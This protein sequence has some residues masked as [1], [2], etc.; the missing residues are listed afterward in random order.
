MLF[1]TAALE[2]LVM[3]QLAAAAL[4]RHHL[5][6]PAGTLEEALLGL[7]RQTGI[8]LGLPN[9]MPLRR[10]AALQG[11]LP[12][13]EA[14]DRLLAGSGLVAVPVEASAWRIERPSTGAP[15]PSP[16]SPASRLVTIEPLPGPLPEIV[17]TAAK[18]SEPLASTP[19]DHA[20]ISADMLERQTGLAGSAMVTDYDNSLAFSNIGPGRN[21]PFLR[22]VGD[23]PFNGQT[24]STVAVMLDDA[25]ITF[26]APDPD[27]RLVD[28]ERVELLKGPQGPLMAPAHWAG[29]IG[30]SLPVRTCR[31]CRPASAVLPRPSPIAAS[32][33]A[34]RR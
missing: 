5:A 2:P 16:K 8:S 10:V 13:V 28:I 14:F 19:I 31:N 24:Q 23:S 30:L 1:L 18:R 34:D 21:R 22:G 15:R 12:L 17:V 29:S 3:P 32:G 25:R 11:D 26:N 27:L 33:A 9:D 4:P 6:L 20:V 7:A